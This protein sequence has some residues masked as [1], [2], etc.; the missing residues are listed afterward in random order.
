MLSLF[1]GRFYQNILKSSL[2]KGFLYLTYLAFLGS[3]AFMTIIFLKWVPMAEDFL[4][5]FAHKMPPLTLT[6]QGITSP[7]KQPYAMTHPTFG[8]ILAL[9][10][11]KEDATPEDIKN[12]FFYV[13]KKKIYANDPIR[14][15]VQVIDLFSPKN[16]PSHP[17]PQTITGE[18]VRSFYFRAKPMF[19]TILS[20]LLAGFVF[21]WKLIDALLCS[22]IALLL[23]QFREEKFS[24]SAL[25]NVSIFSL[26]TVSLL[27]FLNLS[28]PDFHIPLPIWVKI[29]IGTIYLG[30]ALLIASPLEKTIDPS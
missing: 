7:V 22:L 2:I 26:T 3:L 9:N 6:E 24:Y 29:L 14:N 8:T 25:L 16:K 30:F 18:S 15:K 27:Q 12:T 4:D 13:T 28:S 23:N 1:S 21:L 5:W 20:L 11:D 10:T 17:L 19:L